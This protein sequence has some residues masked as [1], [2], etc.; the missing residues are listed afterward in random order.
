MSTADVFTGDAFSL[1]TLTAAVNAIP[2]APGRVSEM[3]I[4]EERGIDTNR[5]SI[6]RLAETV[7]MVSTSQRGAPPVQNDSTLR[8]M[9]DLNTSRIALSD[10]I[11][12]DELIG[13]RAFGSE[14]AMKSLQDE[15]NNRNALM[16]KRIA[17]TI[18]YQRFTAL[19][20]VTKDADGNTLVNSATAF[21][22]SAAGEATIDTNASTNGD[23]RTDV[24]GVIRTIEDGL[25]GRPYSELMA[26][27]DAAFFDNLIASAEVRE[28]YLH[29]E[30][31]RLR[32]RTARRSVFFGGITFEEYRPLAGANPLGTGKGIAFPVGSGIFQSRFGPSDHNDQVGTMGVPF[33]ARTFPDVMGDRFQQLEV[34]S[35][36]LHVCVDPACVVPLDDGA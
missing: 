21:G 15:V 18:E 34:Q 2:Y 13:V 25:G 10:T 19:Q 22:I 35:N 27:V 32:D 31:A 16:M 9:Y 7:S 29:Q 28:S 12:A 3:G 33:V 23:I 30:G 24:S 1:R 17:A 6:E 8:T 14:T 26:F 5:V 4:F 20:G 11:M 36:G